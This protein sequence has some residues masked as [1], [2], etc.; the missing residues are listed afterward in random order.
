MTFNVEF[1]LLGLRTLRSLVEDLER[2]TAAWE[3]RSEDALVARMEGT[4]RDKCTLGN[5]L[6][7]LLSDENNDLRTKFLFISTV[8]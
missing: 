3:R 5:A 7:F 6:G 8:W 1:K 4:S 2:P